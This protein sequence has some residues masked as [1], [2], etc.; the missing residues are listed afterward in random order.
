MKSIKKPLAL[1]LIILNSLTQLA[2]LAYAQQYNGVDTKPLE[3]QIDLLYLKSRTNNDPTALKLSLD[4]DPSRNSAHHRTPVSVDAL[5]KADYKATEDITITIT[6]PDDEP[7]QTK[8]TDAE[9]NV[10]PVEVEQTDTLLGTEVSLQASNQLKPGKYTISITDSQ[11]KTVQQN[12]SWGVLAL[13]TDKSLYHPGETAKIAIGVLNDKGEMVCDADVTLTIINQSTGSSDLLSTGNG[14]IKV[15]DNCSLYKFTLQPDF[16]SSFQFQNSGLYSFQLNAKT[17]NGTHAIEEYITV[18]EQIPFD[19]RRTSATRIYPPL[20]YPMQFEITANQDFEGTITETVPAGFTITPGENENSY[21]DMNTLY[22]DERT[23]PQKLLEGKVLG[24]QTSKLRMPFDGNFRISQGFGN[25]LT[26]LLL[27]Q[28]YAHYGLGGHDGIDFAIPEGTPLYAVDDGN[29]LVAGNGDYGVTVIIQHSWGRSYYGH[30]SKTVVETESHVQKGT[31]I[32]Y[33]GNTGESTGPHLHF[34]IKPENP[35]LEN[36]YLGKIDPLPYLP[37]NGSLLAE[38]LSLLATEQ[39]V[40]AASTS[41]ENAQA[42]TPEPTAIPEDPLPALSLAATQPAF[43]VADKDIKR[44]VIGDQ[45]ATV[46]K[47]KVI[48]WNVKLKKGETTK[49][50]YSYK[51]PQVSPQFYLLGPL[52]FFEQGQE[53]FTEERQWQIAADAVGVGWYNY[54][55]LYRKQITIDHT[56]T[57]SLTDFPVLVSLASDAQ[58]A[59]KA[60]TDA[61]DILFTDATGQTKLSHEIESYSNGTGALVAWVKVPSLSSS[62]DTNIYMYYGNGMATNQQ[63]VSNVWDSNFKAVWHMKEDPSAGAPQF[64]DSTSNNND[65]TAEG[66]LTTGDQIAAIANGGLDFDGDDRISIDDSVS[67]RPSTDLITLSAWIYPTDV[68]GLNIIMAKRRSGNL[69]SYQL[70]LDSTNAQARFCLEP[71]GGAVCLITGGANTADNWYHLAGTWDGTTMRIYKNGTQVGS[72]AT[73][74]NSLDYSADAVYLGVQDQNGLLNDYFNGIIDEARIADTDRS[75]DWISTEYNNQ[76]SPSTF[77]TLG[78]EEIKTYAASN[79]QIMR[80][81]SFFDAT[82]SEQPF[83]Y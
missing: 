83:L 57:G 54:N 70:S 64:L 68:T 45:P 66:T 35:D 82:G 34:G 44:E 80:H 38:N 19:V 67:L 17:P 8:V 20:K 28:F 37:Y 74:T 14:K 30:L 12:F 15:N 48:S 46:E 16:E 49:L 79:E 24:V 32:G 11:G 7:L 61:E 41:A 47:V 3:D 29:I 26:D 55:W 25:E 18:K 78:T 6:N 23:N 53:I 5:E 81:G 1:T 27:R 77:Y 50:S 31:L 60:Q 21:E 9:G 75:A 58:L 69:D 10:V 71:S 22:M 36:G 51:T 39:Q 56:K 43:Q 72:T 42:Q 73:Q 2:P 65:G 76:N 63:D 59:A 62:T 13:N 52:S 4:G 33:S 40:L